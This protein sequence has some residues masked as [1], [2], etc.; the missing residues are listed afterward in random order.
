MSPNPISYHIAG[1]VTQTF[2]TEAA[3]KP[4]AED[5]QLD[6]R[7][8]FGISS[9]AEKL[10]AIMPQV[11]FLNPANQQPFLTA[12]IQCVFGIAEADWLSLVQDQQIIFPQAFMLEVSSLAVGTLRGLIHAKTEGTELHIP[13]PPLDLTKTIPSAVHLDL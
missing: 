9:T 13:L 10:L 5:M 12:E 4:E 11:R 2:H 7:M 6:M 1:T 8:S 3:N